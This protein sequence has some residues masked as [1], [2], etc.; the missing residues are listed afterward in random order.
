MSKLTSII[1]AAAIPALLIA[2]LGVAPAYGQAY[3]EAFNEAAEA[4]KAKNYTLSIQKFKEAAD[5]AKAEGDTAVESRARGLVAKIEYNLGRALLE[6]ESYDQAI[7]HFNSGITQ[8]PDYAKNYLARASALKKLDRWDDAVTAYQQAMTVGTD[9]A[10]TQTARAAETAIRDQYIYLASSTLSRSGN[11]ASR[12]DATE[13]LEHL[14]AM[15]NYVDADSDTY[16]YTAEANKVLGNF[17]LAVE[18]ADKA[19]ELHRGSRTDKA[20]IFFVKGEALMNRG[21]TAEAKAAFQNATFGSYRASAE[22][23][24]ETLGTN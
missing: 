11:R 19:L 13:A 20:K 3:K 16:Y 24:I 7:E 12:A 23:Y 2:L 4:A 9:N 15:Q 10:D 8:D 17:D 22:H 6:K 5:G 21:D 1:R 18:M 14:D